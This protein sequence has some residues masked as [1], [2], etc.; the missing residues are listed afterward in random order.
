MMTLNAPDLW[1]RTVG[2]SEAVC[3]SCCILSADGSPNPPIVPMRV[4]SCHSTY[5]E[6]GVGQHFAQLVEETR[7]AGDLH[8]YLAPGL[9]PN[10]PAGCQVTVPGWQQALL[11]YT[12]L[13]YAPAWTN[14]LLNVGYDRAAAQQ[15]PDLVPPPDAERRF[16]G[17]VGH[18]ARS[19]KVARTLGFDRLELVAVNSHV[20]NVRRLHQRA[21][22]DSGVNDSWLNDAQVRRTRR[23]YDMADAIYVHSDYTRDSFLAAGIPAQKLRRTHLHVDPRFVP[24]DQRP[25]E[26]GIRIVYV[27]RVDITKGM[28][29]LLDAYEQLDVPRKHLTLVGGWPTRRTRR[30]LER[31]LAN[32]EDVTIAP[33][34]PLPVLHSADVFVHPS[35][36][37]G[38]GYAPMEALAC[39][40]PVIV[41][42]DTGMK[43]YV[44]EG[45]NGFV[46]PTGSSTALV[47][48]LEVL[49]ASPQAATHSLLP[50]AMPAG[51]GER[52]T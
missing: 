32:R 4:L 39:G 2:K 25:S 43:E 19:F 24:P 47:R 41:T 15:L 44:R 31:R 10:D 23:E 8:G 42:E 46:V 14:H 48:R 9:R 3:L 7:T 52:S 16:M 27:G 1:G 18:A 22:A 11:R 21:A 20:D 6:G 37:D 30:Y 50:E 5:G 28:A 12:P 40:V 49:A 51:A 38:F 35:Y 45:H 36:E 34:D 33:G 13:R 26:E 17:V 29:V